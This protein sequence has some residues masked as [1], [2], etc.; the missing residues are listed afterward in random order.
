MCNAFPM[1]RNCK[2][3]KYY[4]TDDVET[5]SDLRKKMSLLKKRTRLGTA[6]VFVMNPLFW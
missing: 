6:P 3:V 1:L 4:L 2:V 5:M